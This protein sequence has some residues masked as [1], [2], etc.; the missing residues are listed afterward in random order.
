M[1]SVIVPTYNRTECLLK[2]LCSLSGQKERDFE[3]LVIDQSE[4]VTPEKVQQIL[5]SCQQVHYYH[6]DKS[7]RSLSKNFAI[8][9]AAGDILLFCD[10]DIVV[11]SDFLKVHKEL[12]QDHPEVGALS[13]HLIEAHER[14]VQI[15]VPLRITPYGRFINKANSLYSGYVT[16]LNGGNM[17]F[18]RKALEKV[19]YF[20]EALA[21]TSMLEEP[22][23]AYRVMQA[24]FKLYFSS[25]T[26]VKHYPQYNGNIS[27]MRKKRYLWLRNYFFNQ[28][29]F[30]FRNQRFRY[31][32]FVMVYLSYRSL[33]ETV[34]SRR[35][36][37]RNFSLPFQ[38][39]VLAFQRWQQQKSRYQ[40]SWFTPRVAE[41]EVVKYQNN[42]DEQLCYKS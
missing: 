25:R 19:G 22:D 6:I 2:M 9:K 7:G 34:R 3:V 20:E 1:I 23:I 26:K 18:K 8:D 28:Y 15:P 41:P 30:L 14:E 13:C 37:V 17:S 11:G 16:S 32:P 38:M 24:G 5:Q 40:K 42:Y 4:I 21:G 10:D 29:Y 36:S 39:A 35:F 12:H 27:T 31:F 33:V